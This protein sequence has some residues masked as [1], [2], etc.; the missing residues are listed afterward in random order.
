[1]S[2]R[3]RVG[4]WVGRELDGSSDPRGASPAPITCT[5]DRTALHGVVRQCEEPLEGDRRRVATRGVEL[6]QP[7]QV[8]VRFVANDQVVDLRKPARERRS[9]CGEVGRVGR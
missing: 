5:F 1:M 8:D 7:E 9:V 6:G 4:E 3:N 2:S